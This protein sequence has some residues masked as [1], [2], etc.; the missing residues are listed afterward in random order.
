MKEDEK[1]YHRLAAGDEVAVKRFFD[2]NKQKFVKT[3]IKKGWGSKEEAEDIYAQCVTI[4]YFNIKDGKL[5][6]PL[7]SSLSTYM[8][9]VGRNFLSNEHRML[10]HRQTMYVDP[11]DV[12]TGDTDAVSLDY[13]D[14]RE[15]GELMQRSMNS[16]GD[17]CAQLIEWIYIKGLSTETVAEK[18]GIG[19]LSTIRKRK[20]DCLK[21]LKKLFRDNRTEIDRYI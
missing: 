20:H 14:Y 18:L 1:I 15:K 2:D 9:T 4:L 8:I 10:H 12:A 17:K 19:N 16:I 11:S 13:L 7:K 5:L 6:L 21:K 3:M